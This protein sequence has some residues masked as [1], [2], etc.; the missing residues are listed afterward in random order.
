MRRAVLSA[1][2]SRS[3]GSHRGGRASR[4]MALIYFLLQAR[5]QL[6]L[7]VALAA[8]LTIRWTWIRAARAFANPSGADVGEELLI[9]RKP[10]LGRSPD[11]DGHC[12]LHERQ[13]RE[14]AQVEGAL[15]GSGG[16]FGH[17]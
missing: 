17:D 13:G 5:G 1:G 6:V 3:G 12:V 14:E 10:E 7:A 2:P 11:Q 15:R 16:G 9:E 4:P 8:N